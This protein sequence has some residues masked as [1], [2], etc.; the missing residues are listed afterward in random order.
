MTSASTKDAGEID[1]NALRPTSRKA[2]E[3]REDAE[4]AALGKVDGRTLRR[5]G[6]T[7]TFSTK[8]TRDVIEMVQRIARAENMTMVEVFEAAMKAYDHRLRGNK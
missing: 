2:H 5:R 7:E 6:R 3:A 4:N 1:M 8:T